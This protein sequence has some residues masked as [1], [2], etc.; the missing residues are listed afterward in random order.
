MF[1]CK[2]I[3]SPYIDNMSGYYLYF[4]S[5]EEENAIYHKGFKYCPYCGKKLQ[6]SKEVLSI[7]DELNKLLPT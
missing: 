2:W 7:D 6:I 1:S 4:T 5:C 3:K